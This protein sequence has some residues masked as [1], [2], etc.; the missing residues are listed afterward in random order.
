MILQ[1][2]RV[3]IENSFSANGVAVHLGTYSNGKLLVAKFM[4][5]EW[6]EVPPATST[7]PSL[8]L[9]DNLARSLLDALARHYGA[10]TDIITTREDY[11]HERS[12]VDKLIDNLMIRNNL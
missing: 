5:L 4:Q 3:F 2:T 7:Q 10:S 9:D 11:L 8:Y 6:E 1:P 12:R